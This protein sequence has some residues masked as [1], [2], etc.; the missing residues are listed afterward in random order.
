MGTLDDH[1][2]CVFNAEYDKAFKDKI[3]DP[4]NA[5]VTKFFEYDN[6][7]NAEKGDTLAKSCSSDQTP[8][9]IFDQHKS[10]TDVF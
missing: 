9:Q 5:V 8:V 7:P 10:S 2:P 6:D 1:N 3:V 4:I